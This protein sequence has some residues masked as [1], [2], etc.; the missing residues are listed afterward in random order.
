MK[1]SPW[2]SLRIFATRGLTRQHRTTVSE[3]F[4]PQQAQADG[5]H[6]NGDAGNPQ[7]AAFGITGPDRQSKGVS[8]LF[9]NYILV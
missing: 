8:P 7:H 5:H 2:G 6:G 9:V 3:S 1:N 4:K